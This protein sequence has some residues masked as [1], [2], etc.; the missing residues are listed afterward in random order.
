MRK[1]KYRFL[2]LAMRLP[3]L[4]TN[5]LL[6][7]PSEPLPLLSHLLSTKMVTASTFRRSQQTVR[8]K[9][10]PTPN[11]SQSPSGRSPKSWKVFCDS[12]MEWRSTQSLAL[13]HPSHWKKHSRQIRRSRNTVTVLAVLI[14]LVRTVLHK[15]RFIKIVQAD[16]GF[17]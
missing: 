16:N 4:H 8:T 5:P 1:A 6:D 9:M 13:L 14:G 2:K 7:L 12:R 3:L 17:G 11:C 10:T 15:R